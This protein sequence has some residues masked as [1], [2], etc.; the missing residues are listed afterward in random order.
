MVLIRR[1]IQDI[2][3]TDIQSPLQTKYAY[4]DSACLTRETALPGLRVRP[5]SM[6]VLGSTRDSGFLATI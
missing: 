6:V 1:T 3:A 4:L 2:S 5:A